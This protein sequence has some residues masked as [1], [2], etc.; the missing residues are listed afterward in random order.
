MAVKF[1]ER[2]ENRGLKVDLRCQELFQN[3]NSVVKGLK[4]NPQKE[5]AVKVISSL[6]EYAVNHFNIEENY[7]NNSSYPNY[8]E[9]SLAH[10]IFLRTFSE[11]KMQLEN[12][13]ITESFNNRFRDFLFD[14]LLSH[15]KNEDILLANYLKFINI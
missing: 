4:T 8:L 12:E 9:H 3:I 7:M 11:L 13:G 2:I 5:R 1:A 15:Y 6:E 14:W 10:A